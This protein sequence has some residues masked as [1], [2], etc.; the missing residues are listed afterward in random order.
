MRKILAIVVAAGGIAALAS[1]SAFAA[2][3]VA[4]LHV[5]MPGGLATNVD[6]RWN[7]KHYKH[8]RYSHSH[9]HYHYY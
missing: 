3:S 4:G 5:V 8:R 6:Y 2:P 1:V 9:G 7:H